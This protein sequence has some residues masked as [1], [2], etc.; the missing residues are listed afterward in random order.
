MT[1]IIKTAKE[2]SKNIHKGHIRLSGETYFEHTLR[3]Y[4]KL[5]DAGVKDERVLAATLLHHIFDK[6]SYSLDDL[7][8]E[9]DKPVVD[10]I[11]NYKNLA[12]VQIKDETL[13]KA[14][15]QFI[16]KTFLNL[17]HDLDAM[18]IRFADKSDNVETSYVFPKDKRQ[19][20]ANRALKL[21][22]P[23]CRLLGVNAFVTSLE[24]ES[25]KIL[26]PEEFY[27][28]LKYVDSIEMDVD[29]FFEDSKQ[30]LYELFKEKDKQVEIKSRMKHE[31][32]IYKKYKTKSDIKL[33]DENVIPRY[34]DVAAMRL[35]V[36]NVADCYIA[37][38]IIAGL[39]DSLDE[40]R[41]DY[42]QAPKPNG[43]K[44]L[45][46]ICNVNPKF[47]AEFQIRTHEMHD[48]NDYGIASHAF[49]KMGESFRK[50]INEDPDWLKKI[51]YFERE[52]LLDIAPSTD[53]FFSKFIY[54]FTP[55]GD[56]IEL[57]RGSTILDFAYAIHSDVG[58]KC[59]GGR[60]NGELAK[61]TTLLTD[62]DTVDIIIDKKKSAPSKDWLQY[63]KSRRAK[64]EIRKVM[65]Q[66]IEKDIPKKIS[67]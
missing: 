43:Y 19:T 33:T 38:D 45:H 28:I 6:T 63:V 25:F 49:Y 7:V 22:A 29:K 20:V 12:S 55:K 50:K 1:N 24:N 39:W 57:P 42:I 64:Y 52:K 15:Q 60:V 58:H 56:I 32:S 34:H 17:A 21:Y 67:K 2:L 62:G 9:V 61:L 10:L 5:Q 53:T 54:V 27:K 48:V 16:I 40:Q 41:E 46:V 11:L 4:H 8:K 31:Y 65:A 14:N 37:E 35:L 66:D 44:S 36:E 51:N 3:V 47:D 13:I 18:I 30:V 59:K 23:V 26:Q